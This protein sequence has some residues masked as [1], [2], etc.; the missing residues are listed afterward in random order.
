[1]S[2]QSII[3]RWT[4]FALGV[5][6]QGCQMTPEVESTLEPAPGK[7]VQ[8]LD[9]IQAAQ[10]LQTDKK[11]GFFGKISTLDIRLQMGIP[12]DSTIPAPA[13]RKNYPTFLGRQAMPLKTTDRALLKATFEQ[14]YAF[15]DSLSP[16]LLPDTVLLGKTRT[17]I[18]GPSV[19]FT[20]ERA[21][22]IPK[23]E[24]Y[25]GNRALLP[26]ML[27]ELFHLISRYN[28]AL[29]TELYA[30]IGYQRLDAPLHFPAPLLERRLLNP[31]GI[32][33]NY[34]IELPD[35]TGQTKRYISIITADTAGAYPDKRYIDYIDFRLYP[36]LPTDTGYT[37]KPQGLPPEAAPGFFEQVG[38]NTG[39]IIHPDEILAD[40]FVLLVLRKAG[41]KNYAARPLSE[42]GE[43]LLRQMEAVLRR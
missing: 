27:H 34:A 1:M 31:D 16:G 21:I 13:L 24:L 33:H 37:V 30:L 4:I 38:D 28:P 7:V 22:F 43:A 20:R 6:L 3:F 36:L 26:V 42:K 11:E 35:H 41:P 12:P 14:A 40:N 32:D 15:C 29:R 23:N 10:Q 39:Y 2:D 18:F 19:Y 8:L 25:E 9:S 5:L 17:D